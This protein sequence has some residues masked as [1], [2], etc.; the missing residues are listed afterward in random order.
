SIRNSAGEIAGVSAISRDIGKRVRSERKLR[1]SEER[2]RG[3]FEE[4]PFGMS[5][6]GPDGRLIQVNTAFCRML[7]FSEQ[8]LLDTPWIQLVHP[9]DLGAALGRK[10]QLWNSPGGCVDAE[11]RYIHRSGDVVWVRLKVS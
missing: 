2:F 3:V 4:A 8:E 7:G 5:V 10:D 1:E 11:L 6:A 9:D